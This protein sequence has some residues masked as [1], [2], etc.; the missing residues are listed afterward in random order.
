M[1]LN[2]YFKNFNSSRQQA[3]VESMI[4]S[5]IKMFGHNVK[6]IPRTVLSKDSIFNEASSSE[7]TQACSIEAYIKNI[8]GFAGQGR[9]L[10]QFGIEVRDQ[11][12]FTISKLRFEQAKT[13]KLFIENG[14]AFQLEGKPMYMANSSSALILEG[15][16][17]TFSIDFDM[18]R[19]GDLIY[20]PMTKKLFQINY[21]NYET[22]FYQFGSLQVFDLECELFE[23]SNETIATGDPEIDSVVTSNVMDDYQLLM[24]DGNFITLEEGDHLILED[25]HF[26]DASNNDFTTEADP[27]VDWSDKSPL[28]NYNSDG[29][30]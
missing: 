22:V 21:V 23:Y 8:E 27:L 26:L 4:L 1:S 19:E 2:P 7:F 13:D 9:F 10:S 15:S 30:W 3:L 11:I 5:S 20:M 25:Y 24:E 14:F 6:Y 17:H 16:D 12:T 29:K 28:I 18:P